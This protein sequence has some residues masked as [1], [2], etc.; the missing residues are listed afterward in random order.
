MTIGRLDVSVEIRSAGGGCRDALIRAVG[1]GDTDY[2]FPLSITGTIQ[3]TWRI[4]D[5]DLE[6]ALRDLVTGIIEI[7]GTASAPPEDGYWFDSCNSESSVKETLNKMRN[8]GVAQFLRHHTVGDEIGQIFA[9][10]LLADIQRADQLFA[11]HGP[12]LIESLDYA[13]EY[14]EATADLRSPPATKA[15][16]LYR[17]CILSVIVDR[18]GI[19]L[20]TEE[21]ATKSLQALTNW[22]ATKK[23]AD[24]AR[25]LTEA[26]ARVK[27]LRRQYP[28][29]EQFETDGAGQKAVR[30]ELRGCPERC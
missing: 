16:F 17:I 3:A 28:I 9:G 26:F 24:E 11:E 22:V 4:S 1:P 5:R 6:S 25:K 2:T 19:R 15:A 13:F 21:T 12:R 29:H 20:P 7:R 23:P 14:S 18:F 27:D 30:K 10:N 8:F